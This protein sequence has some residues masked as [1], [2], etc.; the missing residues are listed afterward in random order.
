MKSLYKNHVQLLWI[1][2][3]MLK[4]F[5]REETIYYTE[6]NEKQSMSWYKPQDL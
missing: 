5:N 3:C 6:N 4:L 1:K 2:K